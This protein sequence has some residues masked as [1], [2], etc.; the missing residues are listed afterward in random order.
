MTNK[1]TEH[2]THPTGP[3]APGLVDEVE[4]DESQDEFEIQLE[5]TLR[6]TEEA[7]LE[8]EADAMSPDQ[9]RSWNI[10]SEK[11]HEF[12]PVPWFIWRLS[13]FVFSK[14]YG[15]AELSEG[16]VFGLRRLL[17]AVA[18]DP[19][20]G[21]GEK[22][23]NVRK[24]LRTTGADVIG[25]SSVIHSVC[26]RLK[27]FPHERIWNPI[28][29]DA[30]L[31]A[32]IGLS[33]GKCS[34]AFG[35]GRAML[36]GFAGRIGLTILIANGDINQARQALELL[37]TGTSIRAVGMKVY[38]CDPLQVSVMILSA[39]GCGRSASFGTLSYASEK[40]LDMINNDE[41][42][43]WLSSYVVCEWVRMGGEEDINSQYFEALDIGKDEKEALLEEAKLCIRR[44]HGWNWM[45]A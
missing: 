32:R 17:F 15:E 27:N 19:A 42:L 39:A 23:N 34:Q 20:M 44:G 14:P 12:R 5:K 35:P 40:P 6:E 2:H 45:Q 43:L 29:E 11:V 28:L 4:P 22:T 37:A 38:E 16:H 13:N 30:L 41:E 21:S 36:A 1:E 33:V 9:S 26:R 18:S 7:V 31:R 10:A 8:A 24:A 25:A 3:S